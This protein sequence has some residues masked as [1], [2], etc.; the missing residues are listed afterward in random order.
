MRST[1]GASLMALAMLPR[2]VSLREV[3]ALTAPSSPREI[4]AKVS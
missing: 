1:R 4:C 2:S 3:S